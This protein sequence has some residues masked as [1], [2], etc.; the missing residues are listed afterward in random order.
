M[1]LDRFPIHLNLV[2]T[3]LDSVVTVNKD[4]GQ[5]SLHPEHHPPP[6]AQHPHQAEERVLQDFARPHLSVVSTC[7]ILHNLLFCWHLQYWFLSWQKIYIQIFN[8]CLFFSFYLSIYH[9]NTKYSNKDKP[10][11]ISFTVLYEYLDVFVR[12]GRPKTSVINEFFN[13]RKL[14]CGVKGVHWV[15]LKVDAWRF[16]AMFKV[17]ILITFFFF[18]KCI[19]NLIIDQNIE[20]ACFYPINV[21]LFHVLSYKSIKVFLLLPPAS[22]FSLYE[23]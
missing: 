19:S 20:F 1:W 21:K 5:T 14:M 17:V 8:I 16:A 13:V 7:F 3:E 22:L 10:Q 2:G 15:S 23:F 6:S 18:Y 12:G 4:P 9:F 11:D